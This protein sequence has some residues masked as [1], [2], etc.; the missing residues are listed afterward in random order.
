MTYHF[1]FYFYLFIY[2]YVSSQCAFETFLPNP[3]L[4]SSI[5]IAQNQ[6][7]HGSLGKSPDYHF[8][9][10]AGKPR[11]ESCSFCGVFETSLVVRSPSEKKMSRA[12]REQ[13]PSLQARVHFHKGI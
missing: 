4:L 2:F 12:M 8:S 3:L 11:K 7:C 9:S 13:E 1:Y 6:T 10:R 5:A